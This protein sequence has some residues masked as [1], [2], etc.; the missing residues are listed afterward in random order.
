VTLHPTLKDNVRSDTWTAD[1]K[2]ENDASCAWSINADESARFTIRNFE[3]QDFNC[4][5]GVDLLVW[6][7]SH[8]GNIILSSPAIPDKDCL[9]GELA[10]NFKVQD[11]GASDLTLVAPDTKTISEGAHGTE[12]R[13]L[14]IRGDW[15]LWVRNPTDDVADEIRPVQQFHLPT[16]I[17]TTVSLSFQI[18][19]N[20]SL[21][22][23][24][25]FPRW[26]NLLGAGLNA[27]LQ[28][29]L[30]RVV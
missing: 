17:C 22:S 7:R 10:V 24:L 4:A 26:I 6:L 13:I 14:P 30:P 12:A 5:S 8:E 20:G 28:A 3:K 25:F 9:P 15:K 21:R 23:L 11:P 1:C 27:R 16:K 29:F 19:V 18:N 2:D